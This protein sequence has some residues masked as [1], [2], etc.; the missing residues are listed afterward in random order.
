MV[1]A[2]RLVLVLLIAVAAAGAQPLHPK[3]G[4][5]AASFAYVGDPA[6]P[7]TWK[8]PYRLADGSVDRRRLPLAIEAALGTYRGQHARIPAAAMP[9]VLKKLARAADEIGK[10][11]PRAAHPAPLYRKLAAAVQRQSR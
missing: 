1:R 11:P 5:P 10:L 6:R 4:L 9:D 7:G 3:Y 8:L 2:V